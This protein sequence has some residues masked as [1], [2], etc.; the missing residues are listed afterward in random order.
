MSMY[1]QDKSQRQA[2]MKEA[3]EKELDSIQKLVEELGMGEEISLGCYN[4]LT[5]SLDKIRD[6]LS[7]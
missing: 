4:Q 6:E 2:E 5:N 3:I 1:E 7:D